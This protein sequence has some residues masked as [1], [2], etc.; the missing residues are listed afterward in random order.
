MALYADEEAYFPVVRWGGF[1]SIARCDVNG[2]GDV[3][4]LVGEVCPIGYVVFVEAADD[5]V[6]CLGYVYVDLFLEGV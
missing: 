6:A 2:E 1:L 5:S 3:G 4:G